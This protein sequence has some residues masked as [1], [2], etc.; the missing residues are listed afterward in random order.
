[1]QFQ[2]FMPSPLSPVERRSAIPTI[3]ILL[4]GLLCDRV[5]ADDLDFARDIR[6][7]LSNACYN[8]HGPD[9]KARQADLRL[10]QR[11]ATL[12]STVLSS[13]KMLAR[14]T[15]N[16]PDTRMP[17]ADSIRVLRPRDR[18]TLVRWLKSG[19]PW[20]RNDRHWAFTTPV[21]P[22]RPKMRTP[23]WSRN[24]IDDFVLARLHREQL[25]RF[26]NCWFVRS[27]ASMYAYRSR[28][29]SMKAATAS[30]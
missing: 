5:Q 23:G 8:C 25:T 2:V 24:A 1:M 12:E 13:G 17:P 4:T 18:T 20:P 22:E 11:A 30:S 10:D 14:L 15:S 3:V 19:A 28:L 29:P 7:L 26:G 27:R 21:R 6:P 16:D 9:A